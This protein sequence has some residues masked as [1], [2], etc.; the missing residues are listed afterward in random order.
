ME[1]GKKTLDDRCLLKNRSPMGATSTIAAAAAET[2][3]RNQVSLTISGGAP[4]RRAIPAVRLEGEH[5]TQ[6]QQAP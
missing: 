1:T 6:T 2:C 4:K 5:D 3:P